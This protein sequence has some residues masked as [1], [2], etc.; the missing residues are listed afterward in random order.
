MEN[1]QNI[2]EIFQSAFANHEVEVG[3]H[4]WSAV[5]ASIAAPASVATAAG[6]SLAM[7]KSAAV[8]GVAAVVAVGSFN[9]VQQFSQGQADAVVMEQAVPA[10]SG[11]ELA[12][13]TNA[14]RL[15]GA[16]R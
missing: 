15:G 3:S 14:L 12:I 10:T 6:S 8:I 9:E 11:E 7:M 16:N 13:M 4:V 2:E 5:Q 1:N